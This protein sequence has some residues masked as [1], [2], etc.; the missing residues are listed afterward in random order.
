MTTRR[1]AL[2]LLALCALLYLPGRAA[3]QL[4]TRGEAREA[5][6]VREVV[7]TGRWLV[8]MRP[9]GQL[10][11]KPPLFYWSGMLGWQLVPSS[12]ELAVRLPSVVAGAVGVVAV[13][14]L[15]PAAVGAAG[16]VLGVSF[17]YPV[18]FEP[19]FNSFTSMPDGQ[20]RS[21]LIALAAKGLR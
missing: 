11:R 5:L 21:Q 6:A 20:L 10:T 15:G 1:Q 18:V 12:P 13:A 19:A 17:L 7:D 2:L 16:L 3:I 4:Y 14:C 9:D 8:P